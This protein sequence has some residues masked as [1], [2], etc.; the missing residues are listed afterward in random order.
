M[1]N[2]NAEYNGADRILSIFQ[3]LLLR[4][5]PNEELIGVEMGVAYG[6]GLEALGKLWAGRGLVFGFDT[7]EGHPKQLASSA[8]SL[9]ATCMDGWY[10]K[11]GREKL[12]F[13]YQWAEFEKQGLY[14]IILKQGLVH[15]DSCC[16]LPYIHYCLLDLDILSSMKDGY[17]AVRHRI[18][19]KGFLC[20]HDVVGHKLIPELH[21]WYNEI[22]KLPQWEVIYEGEKEYLAVLRRKLPNNWVNWEYKDA[23]SRSFTRSFRNTGSA[24]RRFHDRR[25]GRRRRARGGDPRADR[26]GGKILGIGPRRDDAC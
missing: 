7:F 16:F 24:S 2:L 8:D 9:E 4:D 19:D 13:N 10:E 11:Y 18:V 17:E 26:T 21:E 15:S 20:L 1:I 5:F 22:K 23:C 25:D 3:K 14:N 12:S 6:G